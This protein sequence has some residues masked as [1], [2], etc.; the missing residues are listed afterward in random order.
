MTQPD[1]TTLLGQGSAFE[2]KLT[3]EGTVK[4]DGEF[5]GEIRTLGTLVVGETADVRANI[6]AATVVVE[7]RVQGDISATDAIVIRAP[8]RVHGNL[9]TPNLEIHKGSVFEGHCRMESLDD[10]PQQKPA[11]KP[12]LATEATSAE[13][14]S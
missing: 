7:G 3:F 10:A 14:G 5:A 6:T 1:N 9:A 13:A 8:A 12:A 11:R 2:G 4:I